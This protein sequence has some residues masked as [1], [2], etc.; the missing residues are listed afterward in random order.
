MIK[1]SN[2]EEFV[3]TRDEVKS[4]GWSPASWVKTIEAKYHKETNSMQILC[5][6]KNR[7]KIVEEREDCRDIVDF[8]LNSFKELTVAA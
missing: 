2:V 5:V 1:K 4:I 7:K 6:N 3:M 8:Y